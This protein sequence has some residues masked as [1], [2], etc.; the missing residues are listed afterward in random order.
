MKN[1]VHRAAG[2]LVRSK[3]AVALTGAGI[4]VESGIPPFRGKGG[5]WEKFDPIEY[6]HID[7]FMKNPAKVWNVFIKEMQGIID[8]ARPNNAHKGLARLE[9]LGILK[10][11]I[12]QNVDGLHQM[13][14]NTDVI[15][16]HGNFAWQRCMDCNNRRETAKID[17]EQIPPRC[18]CGGI[19]KPDCVFFGEMIPPQY[20]WRSEIAASGCDA[21]LVIGTSAG[22]Q[23]AA[24][25][26]VIAKQ[27]GAK[28]IEINL[29][30][31]PLS[32]ESS[33]YTIMG[34]AGEILK[35]LTTE[36]ERLLNI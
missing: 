6:A 18:E 28:V 27:A 8:N 9:K 17:I 4:S 16:F 26:P 10:T 15:E 29:E 34:E 21:M 19:Y 31:T 25:I 7:T 23:P 12:T 36:I 35:T 33:D 24:S 1:L 14:G 13:A 11:I 22:V 20:L 30:R 5:L 32:N 3:N 2:D